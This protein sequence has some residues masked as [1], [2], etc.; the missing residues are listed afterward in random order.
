MRILYAK[1]AGNSD[2]SNIRKKGEYPQWKISA[3]L[4]RKRGVTINKKEHD[5]GTKASV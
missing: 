4:Q 5:Q 1:D 2:V 3:S